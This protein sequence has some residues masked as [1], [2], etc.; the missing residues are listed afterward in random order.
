MA[1]EAK[2]ASLVQRLDGEVKGKSLDQAAATLRQVKIMLVGFRL[3]PPFEDESAARKQLSLARTALEL[4][5]LLAVEQGDVEAF[6]R[7]MAQLKPYYHDYAAM[8]PASSSQWPVIGL[9]LMALLAANKLSE[10]HTELELIPL[11]QYENKFVAF[12]IMLEQELMEGSYGPILKQGRQVPH[13]GYSFFMNKLL[14]TA[15]ERIAA[16]SE[17]A[18]DSISVG[19]LTKL[20]LLPS[21]AETT[22][23]VASRGWSVG[24]GGVVTFP[25]GAKRQ[26]DIPAVP[27]IHQT[28]SYAAE[29][30]RIV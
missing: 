9:N 23:F 10:F 12:P 19:E 26:L 24:A 29:L 21:D 7:G 25:D 13:P 11:E 14:D 2:L 3:S 18:Y 27:V 4:G 17:K 5:V 30:E 16:C 8:L 15:R 22:K 28:L 6:Q 20:L 1:D